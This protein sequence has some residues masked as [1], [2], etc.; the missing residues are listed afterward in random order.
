MLIL[1]ILT[2]ITLV[3]VWLK[4]NYSYWK[5]LNVP[6]PEPSFIVGNLGATF[7]M[8]KHFGDVVDEWYDKFSNMPYIGYFKAFTPAIMVRDP[9]LIKDILIKDFPSFSENDFGFDEKEDPLLSSNPF[10]LKDEKWRSA[11]SILAPLFT[12]NKVKIFLIQY[13]TLFLNYCHFQVK[14]LFP[15]MYS[16]GEKLKQ[17]IRKQG[18]MK[19]IEAKDVIIFTFL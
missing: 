19:D 6:G 10:I 14:T 13:L 5:R 16:A 11:R 4:W 8:K 18:S 1:I 2:I 7:T 17:Y 12:A 15:L 9:D 3:Y